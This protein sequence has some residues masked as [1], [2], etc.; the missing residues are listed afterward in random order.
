MQLWPNL[1]PIL[2]WNHVHT[3]VDCT[4]KSGLRGSRGGDKA[5]SEAVSDRTRTSMH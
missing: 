3:A 4:L 1:G 5:A 2:G